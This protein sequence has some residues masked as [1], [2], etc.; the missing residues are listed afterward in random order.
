[1][2]SKIRNRISLIKSY[3]MFGCSS[4]CLRKTLFLSFV[5]PLF[6][7]IYSIF[8][9]LSDKQQCD[10]SHFYF[11]SLR[12]V[13]FGLQWN[14]NFFAFVLDEKFLDDRCVEYW[15]K[16]LIALADSTDGQ[17]L[18]EKANL[19]VF[20]QNWLEGLSSIKCL[21]KSKRF[22]SHESTIERVVKWLAFVPSRS[23]VLSYDIEEIQLLEDFPEA[24]F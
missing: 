10:L 7:W 2:K 15:E 13:L 6:T 19:N 1:M 8:P 20:R 17:L 11:S 5:L 21:R 22:V 9:F 12:R 16:F 14:T 23:S 4:P 3:R 24:F 18:F